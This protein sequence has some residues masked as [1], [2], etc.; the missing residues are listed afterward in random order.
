MYVVSQNQILGFVIKFWRF[1]TGYS[2]KDF[3][4]LLNKFNSGSSISPP[5]YSRIESG[6]IGMSFNQFYQIVSCL[7]STI[8]QGNLADKIISTYDGIVNQLEKNGYRV[9]FSNEYKKSDLVDSKQLNALISNISFQNM[10]T[11]EKN[12]TDYAQ[13]TKVIVGGVATLFPS[14]S[15][16]VDSNQLNALI[17]NLNFQKNVKDRKFNIFATA[18]AA[19]IAGGA[20][21]FIPAIIDAIKKVIVETEV[22]QNNNQKTTDEGGG[23][24]DIKNEL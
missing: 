14:F 24:H 9:V 17:S 11:D 18:L 7:E 6:E 20:T 21:V 13:I 19:A 5:T 2:Q 4:E 15:D 16:V 3:L 1:K 22:I 10:S 12:K 8:N 23:V